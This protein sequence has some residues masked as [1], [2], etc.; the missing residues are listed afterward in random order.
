MLWLHDEPDAAPARA[1]RNVPTAQ[2]AESVCLD[3]ASLANASG[4]R[5]CLDGVVA[6]CGG[7]GLIGL[8]KKRA[9][10]TLRPAVLVSKPTYSDMSF[11]RRTIASARWLG[12]LWPTRRADLDGS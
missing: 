7:V 4:S 1:W 3:G 9:S 5:D 6:V 12:F 8:A 2:V 11:R 10:S